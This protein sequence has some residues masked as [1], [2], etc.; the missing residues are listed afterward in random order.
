M[1][2][3]LQTAIR[4]YQVK[5]CAALF[6]ISS[7]N[8]FTWLLCGPFE[9]ESDMHRFYQELSGK[10]ELFTV[11]NK[12]TKALQGIFALKNIS[13]EHRKCEIGHIWYGESY[14]KT[15]VNTEAM[16]LALSECFDTRGYRR[17]EWKCDNLNSNS[18]RCALRL[19]FRYEGLFLNDQIVK[20]KNKDTAWFAIIDANWPQV[21]QNF[22]M[23]FE[24]TNYQSLSE[25]ML[26]DN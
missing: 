26:D 14:Q 13:H 8:I 23:F 9:K 25:I 24:C 20:G 2:I 11:F 12:Q 6:E 17:V 15:Y 1:G 21:K 10:C 22:T 3:N 19:G 7:S 16:F 4:P 18:R 5:D